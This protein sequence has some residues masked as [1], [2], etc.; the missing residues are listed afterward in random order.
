MTDFKLEKEMTP[1]VRKWLEDQGYIV[2]PEMWTAHNCDLMGC[3]FNMDNVRLRVE[4]RQKTPMSD[5]TIST[6]EWMPLASHIVAVELKLFRIAAVVH[7]AES[8]KRYAHQSYIAM[9]I[10]TA[11][12]VIGMAEHYEVGVLGVTTE[13]VVLLYESPETRITKDNWGSTKI[14]ESFWRYHRKELKL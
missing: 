13:G 6:R 10:E 8:H 4:M 12:R 2:R 14:T 9:P 3:K 1:I 7:Q 5:H 11:R